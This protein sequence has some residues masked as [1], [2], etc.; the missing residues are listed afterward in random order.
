MTL[1]KRITAKNIRNTKNLK[2]KLPVITAYD[3]VM[4]GLAEKAGCDVLLV[5][6]SLGMVVLGHESTIPVSMDDMVHHTKAVVRGSQKAHIVSDMPFMSFNISVEETVRNASRLI[7]E[8][9]A[10]SV[11]L[12]GGRAIAE[13]V[14]RLVSYG[15][16]VMGHIGLTPQ[17]ILNIGGYSVQGKIKTEAL[18]LLEDAKILE[19]MGAYSIVLELI[20]TPLAKLIT[21]EVAVPTIGIGAGPFCDGQVQVFHDLMGLYPKFIPKHTRQYLNLGVKIEKA[22]RIYLAEVKD[23]SFPSD[24]ESFSMDPEMFGDILK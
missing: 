18:R 10:Q 14:K 24:Q 20:P 21:D 4:A 22:L 6:D 5:G 12:E 7:Q 23:G 11:K 8:G 17:S 2:D 16:P 1:V 13:Q 19:E 15:I 9:G 3:A